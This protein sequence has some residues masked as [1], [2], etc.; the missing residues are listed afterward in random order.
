MALGE[1]G[2][3][4][5][6]D[7]VLTRS[8]ALLRSAWL[9]TRD[10]QLAEDL[11]QVALAKAWPRWERLDRDRD[12]EAYVRKVIYTTFV[13]SWRRRWRGEITTDRIPETASSHDAFQ[14]ADQHQI[15]LQGL[16]Q[17]PPRQRAVILLRFLEDLSEGDTADWLDISRGTVKSQ[18][19]KALAHLRR[20]S[21]LNDLQYTGD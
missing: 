17:L 20:L 12:P 14:S 4:G 11:L 2:P 3:P 16:S 10:Q 21:F 18:T 1:E 5:F 8:P 15:I 19:A 13:S 6:R 9:L 7:F